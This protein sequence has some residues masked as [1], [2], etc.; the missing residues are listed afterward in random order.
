MLP[1]TS[2]SHGSDSASTAAETPT[3]SQD[4]YTR[5]ESK[6][7]TPGGDGHLKQ[8][9]AERDRCLA[10]RMVS[11]LNATAIRIDG[12]AVSPDINPALLQRKVCHTIRFMRACSYC[13]HDIEF[14]LAYAC[15]YFSRVF[16]SL[17]GRVGDQEAVHIVVLLIYTAHSFLLDETCPLGEWHK[18]LFKK[19]CTLKKMDAALFRLLRLL[20]F[21]LIVAEEEEAKQLRAIHQRREQ[22]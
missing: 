15:V 16:P 1:Y 2:P 6:I 19:Y 18:Y 7:K 14:T 8:D 9:R 5:T 12:K 3:A 11:A 20:D 4:S 17:L 22:L 21:R 13:T 10:G